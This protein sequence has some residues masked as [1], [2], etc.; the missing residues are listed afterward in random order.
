[1]AGELFSLG[2]KKALVT[3]G[4]RGLGFAIAKGLAEN[5]ADVAISSRHPEELEEA[6]KD[7]INSCPGR[8]VWT[9]VCDMKKVEGLDE[10]FK[11]VTQETGGIDILVN[12]AGMNAQSPAEEFGLELWHEIIEV[13]LSSVFAMSQAFCR[14]RKEKGGGK[15]V[16]VGSLWCHAARPRNPAYAAS[17]GGLLLLTKQLAVEWA[18]Y[19]INVNAIGPG[20]FKT[21]M[22][23]HVSGNVEFS[24]WVEAST[25]FGRWGEPEELVGA[26]VFLSSA[27]SKFVTGQIV[28][29]DG[30]WVASL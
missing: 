3:G 10:F 28:Y 22:T 11:G 9:F 15:I 16:N 18:K 26:V 6:K 27:A 1:M 7:I 29:V 14:N 30:G 17:K 23:R 2:G 19:G 24:K 4:S 8:N 25:P 5:G 13:N 21:N 12:N 20:F